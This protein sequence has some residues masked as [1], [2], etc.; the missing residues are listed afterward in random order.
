VSGGDHDIAHFPSLALPMR[1]KRSSSSSD[2]NANND[3]KE[4]RL[5]DGDFVDLPMKMSSEESR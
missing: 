3:E 4:F 5:P 2:G 1:L